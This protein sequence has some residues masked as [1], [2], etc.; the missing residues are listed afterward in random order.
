M[1]QYLELFYFLSALLGATNVTV[2]LNIS[3][4]YCIWI[5]EELWD[6]SCSLVDYLMLFFRTTWSKLY[7][8]EK[9]TDS[10]KSFIFLV[11]FPLRDISS[12]FI[13]LWIIHWGFL[14]RGKL[15]VCVQI[16]ILLKNKIH[17]ARVCIRKGASYVVIWNFCYTKSVV[18]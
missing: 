6:V 10:D 17:R 8:R 2:F 4:N 9:N 16:T 15:E 13:I 12:N 3:C 18:M 14:D 7:L 1:W 11:F 5:L